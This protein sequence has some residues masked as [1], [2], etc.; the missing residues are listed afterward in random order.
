M[1]INFELTFILTLN[2]KIIK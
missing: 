1:V 2:E